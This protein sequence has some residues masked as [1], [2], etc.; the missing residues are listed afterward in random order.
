MQ[1]MDNHLGE[2]P[3]IQKLISWAS[4][5]ASIKAMLLTGSLV[6]PYSKVDVFSDYD[7]ILVVDDVYPFFKDK[8]WIDDFGE[9]LVVYWD[10]IYSDE[11]FNI[12]ITGNV[13]Q[14]KSGLKIDFTVW[15]VDILERIAASGQLPG[16]LD[17]GYSVLLDKLGLTDGLKAPTYAAHVPD[18]PSDEQFQKSVEDFYSDAPYV[19]K[20]L[21]RDELLPAKWCLDYDMK[22][23]YLRPMLE[24]LAQIDNDWSLPVGALGKAL[25]GHLPPAV[26]AQLE[27]TFSG[28]DIAD[29][30]NALFRTMELYGS[31]AAKVAQSLGYSYPHHLERQVTAYVADM[32]AGKQ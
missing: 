7:V 26:W 17:M 3:A 22:H 29:N 10:P 2:N 4:A 27:Q 6:N 23:V 18:K 25:K 19:A 15:P 21:L 28:A 16:E 1:A 14:Y 32:R 9:V 5:K 30:W 24:W 12:D 31:A 20:C 13:I 11:D 8:S